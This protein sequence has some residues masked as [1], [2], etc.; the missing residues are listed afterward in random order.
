VTLEIRAAFERLRD[1]KDSQQERDDRAQQDE[2]KQEEGP[3]LECP[4]PVENPPIEQQ[5]Q[6]DVHDPKEMDPVQPDGPPQLQH[7]SQ[8]GEKPGDP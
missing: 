4:P 1:E 8:A 3:F 7:L 6:E 5:P 2:Q